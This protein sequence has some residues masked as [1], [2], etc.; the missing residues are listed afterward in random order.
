VASGLLW[1]TG[2]LTGSL[3]SRVAG[4][5]ALSVAAYRLTAGGVL[6]VVFLTAA[7]RRRP[8]GRA[9]WTRVVVIGLLA[10]L[11]QG[12]YFTAVSLTSVPLATLVTIG[13]APVIV[14]GA[15]RIAGRSAGRHQASTTCLALAGLGLLVGMPSGPGTAAVLAGAG[16]AVLA[17]AGFAAVTLVQARPVPGL[18]ELTVT[19]F[20]FTI[21]GLALMPAA[22]LAGGLGFRPGPQAI[23]LL[24]VLGTGPTAVA[25]TLF[26]RGLRAAAA[27]TAALLALLEPLTG[28]VLAAFILD[29]RLSG[30]GI[31]GAVILAVAVIR[32]VA[33]NRERYG[34]P[35]R[36]AEHREQL[37][38]ARGAQARPPRPVQALLP[39]P[40]QHVGEQLGTRAVPQPGRARRLAA[41]GGE[42]LPAGLDEPHGQRLRAHPL[43]DPLLE[44]PRRVR[45]DDRSQVPAHGPCLLHPGAE[46]HHR[47]HRVVRSRDPGRGAVQEPGGQVTRVDHLRRQ[48]RRPRHEHRALRVPRGPRDPVAGTTA[49]VT[50]A[51]DQPGPRDQQP[52]ARGA[53]RRLLARHLGLAV[54]LRR[55]LV[56][57]GRIEQRRALIGAQG[58]VRGVDAAGGDVGPVRGPPGE[59]GQRPADEAGLPRHLHHRVPVPAAYLVIRVFP[60]PVGGDE[61]R[62]VGDLAALAPGQA[63]HRVPA[64]DRL[65]GNL[66]SQPCRATQNEN[67][68][69]C[70]PASPLRAHSQV[71]GRR[72]PARIRNA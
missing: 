69:A 68:H 67:L 15:E 13:S 60:A 63:G 20:G 31:A 21:G 30:T 47:P 54:V 10:A 33:A 72:R 14:Q 62:A 44:Q 8:R 11:F 24:I 23:A 37:T 42:A 70:S 34:L 2:G 64:S 55:R 52:V 29:Q 57:F 45:L 18:D 38:F 50:R 43:G 48:V 35:P 65:P 39:L 26:F 1:G 41:A 6:I 16:M 51:A 5:P 19:G 58:G 46:R 9:A 7:G 59:R 56:A 66:A 32:T 12:C 27:G 40:G 17:A 25:Y 61:R 3:L 36:L 4:L 28:A 22:A 53:G 49:V 71:H